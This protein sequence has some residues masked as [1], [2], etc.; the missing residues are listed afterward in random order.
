MTDIH[1][2]LKMV[3][4]SATILPIQIAMFWSRPYNSR[5]DGD[6][7]GDGGH[8]DH[9]E[10]QEEVLEE[11][12]GALAVHA[13]SQPAEPAVKGREIGRENKVTFTPL[14][15][16]D[17][18]PEADRFHPAWFFTQ[19]VLQNKGHREIPICLSLQFYL[20]SFQNS[21]YKPPL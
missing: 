17:D 14:Q 2:Q 10:R 18:A 19:N 7:D 12:V 9:V 20:R 15:L 16:R 6:Q 8:G 5:P 3:A 13:R 21:A 11:S 4:N 1:R